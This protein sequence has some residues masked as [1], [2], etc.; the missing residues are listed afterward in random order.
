MTTTTFQYS[1]R[2]PLGKVHD[3]TVEASSRESATQMLHRD[4]F[5]VLKLEDGDDGLTLFPRA[6]KR[7]DIIYVANQLA[8][9][10]DTGINLATALDGIA[11][12]QENPTLKA[13]LNDLK[14]RVEGGEDFSAALARHP[15]CFDRTF[16][17]LIKA[18]EQ[19]GSLAEILEQ[20][21]DYLRKESENRAKVRAAMAYPMV[22]LVLAIGVTIFL[23]TYV[24]PKFEPLFNRKGVK[25]P[26]PTIVM[27]AVSNALIHYWYAWL[28]G[29]VAIT[30]GIYFGRRTQPGRQLI[31]WLKINMPIVGPMFRKVTIS[32]SIRTLGTMVQSGVSM[33]DAIRLSAE[34]AGNYYYERSWLHVLDEITNGNRICEALSGNTL[35]PRTLIQMIGSGEETGKLD[36]VLQKVSTYYDREVETSLKTV[37]SMIEPLMIVVM[38]VVVGGI[39]LGLLLPIFSL[40]R[41]VG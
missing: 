19:T 27:I 17:A 2:D 11:S 10:V 8:I 12:Q 25:L 38:G 6:I 31:D 3:G 23:L 26:T 18:S 14:S 34:V 13:V 30:V 9:M 33:L 1:A 29:A 15:K 16:V 40:S 28:I 24:M 37:T 35:F 32:R 36:Q 7:S 22:M 21:A 39:G 4:G 41:A 20:I 5:H